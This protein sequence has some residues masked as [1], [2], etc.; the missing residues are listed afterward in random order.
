VAGVGHINPLL[1]LLSQWLP[2]LL[3]PITRRFF[4]DAGHAQKILTRF[5]TRW[6]EPDRKSFLYPEVKEL[7]VASLVEAQR[8]GSRGP[9]YDGM[10]LGRN[11]GF[12]LED[13]KFPAI[14][15]WHG[16]LDTQIPVA[17][18]QAMAKS[19]PQCKATYYSEEGHISLIVNHAEDIVKALR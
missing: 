9:A 13:I 1:A 8:Q 14:Y 18:G 10:L 12:H 7:M 19:I 11:W 17:V 16:E 5:S 3:L 6:V 2:W 4:K 15:L